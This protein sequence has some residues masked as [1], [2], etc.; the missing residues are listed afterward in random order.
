MIHERILAAA[1]RL[2]EV[3]CFH[4][5]RLSS[6]RQQEGQG[7]CLM[8][9]TNHSIYILR[10]PVVS[11]SRALRSS[12]KYISHFVQSKLVCFSN[13][14]WFVLL[15]TPNKGGKREN[16]DLTHSWL[17]RFVIHK[18]FILFVISRNNCLVSVKKPNWVDT[19]FL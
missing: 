17:Y 2:A 4:Q 19:L 8:L 3:I 12:G 7:Q 10:R 13:S 14:R 16:M 9:P 6:R 15:S 18:L 5:Q 11:F 1:A